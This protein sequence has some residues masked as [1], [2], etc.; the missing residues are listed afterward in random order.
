MRK[1][2]PKAEVTHERVSMASV[3]DKKKKAFRELYPV[4][5]ADKI[6]P[7][8]VALRLSN[9]LAPMTRTKTPVA[10]RR[11]MSPN[12]PLATVEGTPFYTMPEQAEPRQLD[13]TNVIHDSIVSELQKPTHAA[14]HVVAW[15]IAGNLQRLVEGNPVPP[16]DPEYQS[17]ERCLMKIVAVKDAVTPLGDSGFELTAFFLTGAPAGLELTRMFPS[18][19]E[20]YFAQDLGITKK[21]SVLIYPAEL[22]GMAGSIK[23]EPARDRNI[24]YFRDFGATPAQRASNKRLHRD[25]Q[26][27]DKC[28]YGIKSAESP[29]VKCPVTYETANEDGLRCD[30]AVLR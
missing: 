15:R 10:Q 7:F 9:A 30:L 17:E 24:P 12:S 18:G 1:R 26:D 29:C 11:R 4:L 23:L 6:D 28:P 20:I 3:I 19:H 27:P 25:R 13:L 21:E 14:L 5:A 2:A 8:A 22:V 16:W